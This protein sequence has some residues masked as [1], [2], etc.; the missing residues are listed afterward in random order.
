MGNWIHVVRKGLTLFRMTWCER[1]IPMARLMSCNGLNCQNTQVFRLDAIVWV[2]LMMITKWP[3]PYVKIPIF[4]HI[5]F[6]CSVVFVPMTIAD[7]L[8][9]SDKR[10]KTYYFGIWQNL[11][12]S[13]A[14]YLSL[15]MNCY[16]IIPIPGMSI[17]K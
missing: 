6:S 14:G 10:K 1:T 3:W 11:T 13:P 15:I 16:H 17:I 2:K 7:W 9:G 4:R 12:N 8:R 5:M